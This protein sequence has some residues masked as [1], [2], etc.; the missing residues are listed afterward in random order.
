MTRISTQS[1]FQLA[2][3]LGL[4]LLNGCYLPILNGPPGTIGMQRSRAVLNDP[5]P[6]DTLGPSI[7]GVRPREFDLPLSEVTG[8]QS[9]PS[10]RR[11]RTYAPTGFQSPLQPPPQQ[12]FFPQ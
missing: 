4:V 8:Y 7:G 9:H 1:I 3:C 10:A 2:T 6:S 12:Q 11:K 5:F